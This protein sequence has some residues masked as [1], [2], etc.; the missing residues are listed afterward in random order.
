MR[1]LLT[2]D[3]VAK[4]LGRSPRW[5][6]VN[7]QNFI[8]ERGDSTSRNGRRPLLYHLSSLPVEARDQWIKQHGEKV[9]AL[10]PQSNPVPGQLPL[11]L[12]T[13]NGPNLSSADQEEALH[14]FRVIEP[15]ISPE[16]HRGLWIECKE[17]KSAVVAE[18][19]KLH[20]AKRSTIY[21]WLGRWHN[22]GL[23]AL[24]SKDREDKGRPRALNN[25]ALEFLLSAVLPCAGSYGELSA[26]E[27]YRAYN[28]ER[29]WRRAHA[30]SV[31][32]E[33]EARKY[34]VYVGPGRL[35]LPEAQLPKASY[36]T[37]ARWV[38]KVPDALKVMAKDGPDAFAATQEILSFR[39]L[40]DIKPLDYVV[41]DHRCLD[42]W[43]LVREY[44]SW[45]LV[46]P[47]LSAAVDMRTRKWLAW[48]I[49]Q[50]PS[51]DAI[52]SVLKTMLLK[53]GVPKALYLDNGRD[54][55]C[56]WLEG[57]KVKQ[58]QTDKI[59]QLRDGTR[60]VLE[61]LGI[62]VHH[63][64]VKRARSKIIEPCF[65]GTANFDRTLDE[66]SGHKPTARPKRLEKLLAQHEAWIKGEVEQT[67]FRTIE[68]ITALYDELLNDL[69][70]REHTG[71]G[72]EKLTPTGRGWM[73]PNECW[74]Q[75][76]RNVEIRSVSPEILQFAFR[77]RKKLKVRNG[78]IRTTLG[79]HQYHF[80]MIGEQRKLMAFNG[81][82]VELAYDPINIGTAAAVY[83]ENRFIGLA[84][85][86]E[87][88]RMGEEGFVEDEKA[89]RAA[90]R[91]IR[92]FISAIHKTV[93]VPGAE[94][95]AERRQAVRPAR[96]V[97]AGGRAVPAEV[98]EDV[99]QAS[100]AY[101]QETLSMFEATRN[102]PVELAVVQQP[103]A[104]DDSE[105]HFFKEDN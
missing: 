79:G 101:S 89:R 54:Y 70:E 52:A 73:C 20:G 38:A 63:A 91:E 40:S 18:I 57:N 34:A 82:E 31:L 16:K 103:E 33:F 50:M 97:A 48:V 39:A 27:I 28:E 12:T 87:L 1:T 14:R 100:Q 94:E 21:N 51:S 85:N 61:T 22:G 71:E 66:Y 4:L 75:H 90:R 29:D 56:T 44:R 17:K 72:M 62:R 2:R 49:V 53:F 58:K 77:K 76:I 7:R 60:G 81:R 69:N 74:E 26:K 23:P 45:K 19:V 43:C 92:K 102:N 93:H 35:L 3:E 24:V 6:E 32:G 99:V 15:L 104:E 55:R 96:L 64:I 84:E 83:F 25:S 88:R 46:R 30:N 59:K 80:R 11:A 47:W 13:P 65:R 42:L 37:F 10:V 36:S 9:V 86:V 105:F 68:Q 78:E 98:A 67:A 5:V 41:L 95:R 8:I